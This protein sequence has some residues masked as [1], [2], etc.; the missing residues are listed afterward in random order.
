MTIQNMPSN[1]AHPERLA[2][3]TNV[4]NEVFDFLGLPRELCDEVYK[5]L[6]FDKS[7]PTTVHYPVESYVW[8]K[9]HSHW[10][11]KPANTSLGLRQTC[12][13]NRNEM[14]DT[15]ERCAILVCQ[16]HI[17][18]RHPSDSPQ[19]PFSTI[20]ALAHQLTTCVELSVFLFALDGARPQ[21]D[22]LTKSKLLN[23][24]HVTVGCKKDSLPRCDAQSYFLRGLV[25]DI[26]AHVHED[27]RIV[28]STLGDGEV[29][30]EWYRIARKEMEA[31][32]E[33]MRLLQ[34]S[35][36]PRDWDAITLEDGEPVMG[37][38]TV[39]FGI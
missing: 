23:L 6:L 31:I 8:D 22:W 27:V 3:A 28:W 1:T 37:V 33:Q 20:P 17:N 29:G 39:Q 32:T 16:I 26:Y 14:D 35:L 13:L 25:A 7:I 10:P 5:H 30:K 11:P 15:A 4:G 21:W 36:V 38:G 2:G 24:L 19:N 9:R 12:S 18:P 34:G